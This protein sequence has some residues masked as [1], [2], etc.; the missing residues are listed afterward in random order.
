MRDLDLAL[1]K[2][3]KND[4]ECIYV[5]YAALALISFYSLPLCKG[6]AW[7]MG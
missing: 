7:C 1:I 5:Y 6:H 4:Y 3:V 2:T